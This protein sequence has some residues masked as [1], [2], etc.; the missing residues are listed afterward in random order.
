MNFINKLIMER[1]DLI[2]T[3]FSGINEEEFFGCPEPF[4]VYNIDGRE[5]KIYDEGDTV[6]VKNYNGKYATRIMRWGED[7]EFKEWLLQSL[8]L[9]LI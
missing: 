7:K 3:S 9:N 4:E 1:E 5:Y 8:R 6:Y 2:E